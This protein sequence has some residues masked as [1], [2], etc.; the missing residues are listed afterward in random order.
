MPVHTQ[1]PGL[2]ALVLSV[3][4]TLSACSNKPKKPAAPAIPPIASAKQD[5]APQIVETPRGPM[6]T[7]NDVLFDF[8]QATLRGDAQ[9][10]IEL[11]RNY[12]EENPDLSAAIEGHADSTGDDDY[13]Y[14]LSAKRSEAVKQAIENIGVEPGRLRVAAFG[15]SR[16]VAENT[17][18]TGRQSNRRVEVIFAERN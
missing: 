14:E 15:E 17:T 18:L 12:L 1:L 5:I 4:C 11:V 6:L 13:N 10:S 8:D 7:I 2:T 16:P 3:A 9:A